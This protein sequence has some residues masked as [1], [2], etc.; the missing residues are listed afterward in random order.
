M[1]VTMNI[2]RMWFDNNN[3]VME[4][5]QEDP[6]TTTAA[7]TSS[8]TTTT[9]PLVGSNE[10]VHTTPAQTQQQ[11]GLPPGGTNPLHPHSNSA[12]AGVNPWGSGQWP[13]AAPW[14]TSAAPPPWL[15]QPL[16]PF[17]QAGW[18]GYPWLPPHPVM[19]LPTP[20]VWPA[21]TQTV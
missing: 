7:T 5:G 14:N 13:W 20:P 10:T 2:N 19:P 17:P 8:T 15:S 4:L 16:Q 6:S 18:M 12:A 1:C 3:C 21:A 9:V 11:S